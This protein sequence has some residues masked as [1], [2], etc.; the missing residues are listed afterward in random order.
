MPDKKPLERSTQQSNGDYQKAAIEAFDEVGGK[1]YLV[2]VA[3]EVPETFI[4]LLARILS[5]EIL[6]ETD[7]QVDQTYT[8]RT[9][10]IG[11]FV[12]S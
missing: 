12:T 5:S 10:E 4:Q 8:F 11:S 2:A 3:R 7:A 9:L 6:A 1:D